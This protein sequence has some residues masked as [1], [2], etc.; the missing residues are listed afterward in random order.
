MTCAIYS[1]DLRQSVLQ[2]VFCYRKDLVRMIVLTLGTKS[3]S[4]LYDRKWICFLARVSSECKYARHLTGAY[5]YLND[6]VTIR[7]LTNLGNV[8][9]LG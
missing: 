9:T 1:K 2:G 3:H 6:V 7:K 4:E 5:K 8:V